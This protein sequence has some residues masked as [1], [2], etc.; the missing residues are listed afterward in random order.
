[1]LNGLILLYGLFFHNFGVTIVIFTLAVRLVILPLT[2]RQLSAAKS[3]SR[4]QPE[5]A[6]IQKKYANDRQA[7]SKAQMELY[8]TYGVNPLGCAVPTLI[9]FPVWIGLYQSILAAL[10]ATPEN[11]MNLSRHLYPGLP[12]V[13]QLVPLDS[14][15]LWLDLASPDPLFLLPIIVAGSGWLQQKMST[16]PTDD[17]RQQQMNQSMQWMMPIMFGFFTVSFASGLAIY[18]CIS[19]TISIVVQYFVSYIWYPHHSPEQFAQIS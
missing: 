8:K 14:H 18:W 10:A 12:L 2:I 19:N 4:L 15:F 11:L 17:P 5:L 7:L 6:K 1:M 13:H 9:Q 3:M 16:M